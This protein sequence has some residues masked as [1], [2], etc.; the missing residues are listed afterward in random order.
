MTPLERKI[1]EFVG[2][3][4][5]GDNVNFGEPTRAA[6]YK[7]VCDVSAPHAVNALWDARL[8]E[9]VSPRKPK[10]ALRFRVTDAGRET[11]RGEVS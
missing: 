7:T 1:L 6:I 5:D 8:I 2:S 4:T 10:S 11:L 3:R 9:S